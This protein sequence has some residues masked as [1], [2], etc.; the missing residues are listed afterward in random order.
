MTSIAGSAT[1]VRPFTVEV[2]EEKVTDL[3]RRIRATQW[4]EKETVVD[5]SQGVP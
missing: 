5:Q 2:P 4:P 3:R 1:E